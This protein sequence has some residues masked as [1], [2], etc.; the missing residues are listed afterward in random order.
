MSQKKRQN[1]DALGN[2][3][4][5]LVQQLGQSSKLMGIGGFNRSPRPSIWRLGEEIKKESHKITW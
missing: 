3:M 5:K 1:K 4:I 2:V